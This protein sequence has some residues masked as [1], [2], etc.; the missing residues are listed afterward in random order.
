MLGFVDGQVLYAKDIN[1]PY[2]N[3][4]NKITITDS[5]EKDISNN[6]S[7]VDGY[8][9]VGQWYHENYG[10]AVASTA[11][12][13]VSE[14]YDVCGYNYIELTMT[15]ETGTSNVGGICFYD[16]K[17]T[18]LTGGTYISSYSTTGVVTRKYEIP[19][20]AT[21]FRTTFWQTSSSNY[22][23]FSC[24]LI[25]DGS[26]IRISQDMCALGWLEDDGTVTSSTTS[27]YTTDFI[28]VNPSVYLEYLN[29]TLYNIDILE[30]D[31]NK[32]AVRPR[33]YR[34]FN[35]VILLDEN[36]AYIK[37]NI[38]KNNETTLSLSE[39][40]TASAN[41]MCYTPEYHK[42]GH[43]KPY[44]AKWERFKIKNNIKPYPAWDTVENTYSTATLDDQEELVNVTGVIALPKNYT[45]NGAPT[46]LIM[47]GHGGHG[48]VDETHWY[49]SIDIASNNYKWTRTIKSLLAA[50]YAVFDC[51]GYK[52]TLYEEWYN[53]YKAN[54]VQVS[55]GLPQVCQA[56]YKCY[57]YLI[58]NYNL[59]P[60]IYIWG[61]SQGGHLAMNF[62]W[63]HRDIVACVSMCAGQISLSDQGYSYQTTNN[64]KQVGK[65]LG[66]NN[67]LSYE[68]YK[69]NP[70][71][72]MERIVSL[73]SE[74]AVSMVING[75]ISA[76][77]D[78]DEYPNT[79]CNNS[80]LN[81]GNSTS[82]NTAKADVSKWAGQDIEI[83]FPKYTNASGVA[84]T[85]CMTAIL[86]NGSTIKLKDMEKYT[87]T[88][89]Y[90][91]M[92]IYTVTLP[93]DIKYLITS[94][95]STDAVENGRVDGG[96]EFSCK[97][98][99]DDTTSASSSIV[100]KDYVLGYNT[101]TK[102]FYGTNDT[103][104]PQYH[105]TKKMVQALKNSK[106]PTELRWFTGFSHSDVSSGTSP[107]S[108][109]ETLTWFNRF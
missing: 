84:V 5:V 53:M 36:T 106:V 40:S 11:G 72:P 93:D 64:K 24:K 100:Y 33:T 68:S 101:P 12:K 6:L 77:F 108:L 74:V 83:T 8:Y 20:L 26:L 61:N 50:G 102:F 99:N 98:V 107:I 32:K 60:K 54:D 67:Y 73:P 9:I 41:I 94:I 104:L 23:T 62:S 65:M 80:T 31:I 37:V 1:V 22:K 35:D 81:L 78:F 58:E 55:E 87:D 44:T 3:R 21:T 49:P 28:P 88:I 39:I 92:A 90:G 51:N 17:G 27:A 96:N 29:N 19:Y 69:A 18:A 75:D 105:Y 16:A 82:F 48:Y 63:Y 43:K 76:L 7:W 45:P 95:F 2:F 70:W 71:D 52:D 13:R 46:K 56:Y 79:A 57:E 34:G 14:A 89:T 30:F 86:S 47:M 97:V 38:F 91:A 4:E 42:V 103:T 25:N 85:N 109:R 66:F 15:A 10:K 59:N